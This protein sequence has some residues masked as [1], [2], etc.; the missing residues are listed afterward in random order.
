MSH[1]LLRSAHLRV[2]ITSMIAL[3]VIGAT[4]STNA[5]PNLTAT[6]DEF[7]G[8]GIL[9]KRLLFKDEEQRGEMEL[10]NGWSHR[11][12]A[13]TRLIL[14]PAASRFAEAAITTEPLPA[15]PAF[16]EPVRRALQEQVLTAVPPAS[17]DVTLVR[18]TENPG[19][20]GGGE[21]F[22]V[23]IA[24]KALGYTFHRSTLFVNWKDSRLVIQLTAPETDFNKLAVNLRYALQTWQ[25]EEANPPGADG[26][27]AK[28]VAAN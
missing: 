15:Q 20:P 19:G 12:V 8:S 7:V 3:V 21:S 17:Q 4:S 5:A 6:L 11:N 28:S 26:R 27:S 24:Y 18:A 25:W 22:E 9:Y 16:I 1:D 14:I 10:P 23:V 13:P 2:L